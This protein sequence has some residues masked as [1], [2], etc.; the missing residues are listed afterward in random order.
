MLT[1]HWY[2]VPQPNPTCSF[3][4]PSIVA[5][6]CCQSC[7]ERTKASAHFLQP[8]DTASDHERI[9]MSGQE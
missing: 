2:A 8:C 9:K 7:P 6:S 5:S 1:T 4:P 3:C